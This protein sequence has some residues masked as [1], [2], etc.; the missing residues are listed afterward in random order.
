M[1]AIFHH[2]FP[3][4]NPF[5]PLLK[6]QF[7][8]HLAWFSGWRMKL[9]VLVEKCQDFKAHLALNASRVI[10]VSSMSFEIDLTQIPKQSRR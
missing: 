9:Q 10:A 6:M 1:E 5:D 4:I 7:S 2:G 3:I 8:A